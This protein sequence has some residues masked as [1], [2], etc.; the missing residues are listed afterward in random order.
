MH[1]EQKTILNNLQCWYI[2]VQYCICCIYAAMIM[3]SGAHYITKDI[4]LKTCQTCIRQLKNYLDLKNNKNSMV[5]CFQIFFLLHKLSKNCSSPCTSFL[6]SFMPFVLSLKWFFFTEF[7]YS[8]T[9]SLFIL[10]KCQI[11]GSHQCKD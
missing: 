3:C 5:F 10:H 8:L 1:N 6:F 9:N 7:A 11:N 2:L 4:L